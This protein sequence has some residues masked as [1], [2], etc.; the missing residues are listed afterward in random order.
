MQVDESTKWNLAIKDEMDSLSSNQMWEFIELPEGKKV[1]HNKWVYQIKE[2]RDG[3]KRHK[4]KFFEKGFQQK[5]GI[6]YIEIFSSVVKLTTIRLVL[7]LA[8]NE[9]LHLE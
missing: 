2:E 7:G 6:D 8:A 1:L 3:I 9:G 4:A 5:E